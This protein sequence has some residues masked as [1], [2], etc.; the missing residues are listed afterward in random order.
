MTKRRSER[1]IVAESGRQLAIIFAEALRRVAKLDP[2]PPVEARFYPYAGLHSTIRLRRGKIYARISDLL[3]GSPEEVLYALACILVAKLYSLGVSKKCE[4]IYQDY[5]SQPR[6][7]EASEAARRERGY[8]IITSSRGKTYDLEEIFDNLNQRYFRGSLARPRLSWSARRTRIV[9]G[10]HDQ[11]HGAIVISRTLDS[12]NIPRFV[13][14]YVLYHEMLH[15]KYPPKDD[16]SRT[17]YHSPEFRR[18]ERRFE[19]FRE[20]VAWLEGLK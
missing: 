4:R 3:E 19:Q 1:G 17:L 15:L 16:G 2:A 7:R 10:H 8:K 18:E 6:L 12:P 14:E 20:A 5:I 9:L 13:I 11:A